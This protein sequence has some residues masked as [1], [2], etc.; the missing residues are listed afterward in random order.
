[1]GPSNIL[2][3]KVVIEGKRKLGRLGHR[4]EDDIK[5]GLTEIWHRV[6]SASSER[7]PVTDL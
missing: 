7:A 5:V 6:D 3:S 4:W 1:M 2:V